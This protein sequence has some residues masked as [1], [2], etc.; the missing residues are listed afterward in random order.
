MDANEDTRRGPAPP[1]AANEATYERIVEACIALIR[2]HGPTKATVVDVARALGMSHANVYRHFASKAALREV[3]VERFLH[4]ISGPLEEIVRG[5][6]TAPERLA[7]WLRALYAAKRRKTLD[8]PE[9]FAAYHALTVEHEGSVQRHVE[10]LVSQI[11]A[12]VADGVRAGEFRPVDATLTGWAILRGTSAYHHPA[13]V[14]EAAADPES[15]ARLE[16]LIAL[17]LAGL[18]AG[19]DAAA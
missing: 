13:L 4:A 17:L 19:P 1:T 14:R 15:D 18:R 10:E 12:I 5:P 16:A 2:R 11:A 8:D 9:L 7:A 6:G 3:V